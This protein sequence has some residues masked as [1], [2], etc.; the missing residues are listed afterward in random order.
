MTN[1][2]VFY[3]SIRQINEKVVRV[4]CRK[5]APSSGKNKYLSVEDTVN[6]ASIHEKRPVW[7]RYSP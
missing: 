1:V 4:F 5:L 3:P 6:G 2:A 7:F